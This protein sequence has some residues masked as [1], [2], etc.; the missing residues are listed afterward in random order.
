MA[1][2]MILKE[3]LVSLGVQDNM[4][5]K[6]RSAFNNGVKMSRQFSKGLAVAG[7]AAAGLLIAANTGIAKFVTGLVRA[8]DEINRFAAEMGKSREE[9][10]RLHMTLN[11]MGHTLEE[12]QASPELTR[13]FRRLQ[14]DAAAVQLPDMSEGLEQVRGIQ[15]EFL[16]FRQAGANAIQWVGHYLLK[17]LAQPMEK[18]Q[19]AFSGLNDNLLANIPE[20]SKRIASVMASVVQITMAIVHGG[21]LIFRTVKNIFDMIPSEILI[22]TGVLTA[23]A[24]FIRAGPIGKLILIF[25]VLMLLVEDFF[26]FLDGGEALLGGLWR[27]LSGMFDGLTDSGEDALKFIK[28]D[29]LPGIL[30]A[31]ITFFPILVSKAMEFVEPLIESAVQAV[32]G[33]I[34]VIVENIPLLVQML[35]VV[36]NT[37][38]SALLDLLPRLVNIGAELLVSI[39]NG[40][41]EM[42]PELVTVLLDIVGTL[43]QTLVEAIPLILEAG[44]NLIISLVGGIQSA[45]PVLLEAVISIVGTLLQLIA[46][47][48]PKIIEAGIEMI[49][50]LVMGLVSMLP[51]FYKT[52]LGLIPTAVEMLME[53]LPLILDAAINIVL[54]LIDGLVSMLPDLIDTVIGLVIGLVNAIVNMLPRIIQMGIEL[55]MSLIR[56]ILDALPRI[57]RAIIDLV[58]SLVNAIVENLPLLIRAGIDLILSLIRGIVDATPQIIKAIV[59]LIPMLVET[60]VELLPLLIEAGIQLIIALIAGIIEAIPDLLAAIPEII[61]AV[62]DGLSMLPSMLWDVGKSLVTSLWEGILSM[63]SWLGDK[64]SGF[65]NNIPLIGGLLGGNNNNAADALPGHAEGGIFNKPHVATFAEDGPE[66]IV[67][68]TK[69]NRA[70]EVLGGVAKFFGGGQKSGDD[71]GAIKGIVENLHAATKVLSDVATM[72]STMDK[73][74]NQGTCYQTSNVTYNYNTF[75]MKSNYK[76]NDTSGKPQSVATAVD[77]TKQMQ[78]RNLQGIL[79]TA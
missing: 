65:V 37:I 68:L 24:A 30:N 14:E 58:M 7:T 55:V 51:E 11:A 69:P 63:G 19:E 6:L 8:D 33:I 26:T 53:N 57:I 17:Y 15:T 12:I 23:F 66:A 27:F 32:E 56:G 59:E 28:E 54:S 76:I 70:R 75:D 3:Y 20:W 74:L 42:I 36:A 49:L 60:I 44:I 48:F 78:M 2:A 46:E 67:P 38:L 9:A 21:A 4:T 16:R 61:S 40:I 41:V 50:S 29:L 31:I 35:G 79:S 71:N 25:T 13:Q 52:I 64:V 62:L 18:F 47:S 45:I 5:P 10:H 34:S 73:G 1:N 77:R 43:I 72:L 22:L 39:I